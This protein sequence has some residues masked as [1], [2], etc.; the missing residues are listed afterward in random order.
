MGM[1]MNNQ[2]HST[3]QEDHLRFAKSIW[4]G[5]WELLEKANRTPSE[6]ED[7]LLRAYASLYHWKQV[8][9]QANLQRGY[10]MLSRVYLAQGAA[11]QALEWALKCHKITQDHAASMEDFDLAYAQ[12]GLARAY[13]MVGELELAREHRA[14]AAVLGEQI[15]DPEDREIFLGDFQ[16]GDWFEL[17]RE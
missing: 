14:E 17:D 2:Q 10:W 4:N 3:L 8:G 1:T 9:T 16:G 13:A 7:L 11:E 6:E 15:E 12:E 5:I